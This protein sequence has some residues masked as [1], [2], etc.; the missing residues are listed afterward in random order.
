[1]TKT[2]IAIITIQYIISDTWG[3]QSNT[4]VK[5]KYSKLYSRLLKKINHKE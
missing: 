3:K 4:S 1:M 2:T 5:L